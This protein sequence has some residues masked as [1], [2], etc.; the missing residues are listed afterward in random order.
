[1]SH[2]GIVCPPVTGHVNPIAAV[3]RSL[4][5]RGHQVT[6]FHA[7]DMEAKSRSEGLQFS[8]LG[9]GDYPL[10]SLTNCISTLSSLSGL[11]A[12][13]YSVECACRISN[14]ILRDGPDAMLRAKVDALLVDQNEPSGGSVAEHLGIPF[15]SVCT[16]LPLNRESLIP[17]PFVGWNFIDS[18]LARL[19]NRAGYLITDRLI[20]P[21]QVVLNTYRNR[22][23][24]RP[25]RTPDD[26]FSLLA[27]IAQMPREFD[28]PRQQVLDTFHYLGPW[29][30]DKSS[31][32]IAFP[33]EK[34]DGQ[35]IIYGSIGTLQS[36]NNSYFRV[37]AEAC[38]GL[39]AQLVLTLGNGAGKSEVKLTGNTLVVDY[40]PQLELLARAAVTLTHAGMNTTQQSLHFGVP[41]IGIPLVHDQPAIAARLSRTGAGIIIPPARLTV[42]RLRASILSLLPDGSEFRGNARRL[43]A[44]IR[45]SGGVERAA[46]IAESIAKRLTPH[47]I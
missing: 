12:L 17:P 24:L 16:S 11:A 4:V 43:Q 23:K 45:I 15:L 31:S 13:K 46:D 25:I 44:A 14:L 40:A 28:F 18:P 26:T 27:T 36:A 37:M 34:L 47:P 38:R 29:F 32:G 5:R 20:A 3:G 22:W 30:D 21:I 33:F 6:L 2:F 1:M 42:S 35:P 8:A 7:Q 39:P 9:C 19:R 10:G 41:A